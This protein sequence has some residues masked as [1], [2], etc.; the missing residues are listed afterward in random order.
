MITREHRHGHAY[1]KRK[2]EKKD[3]GENA[4]GFSEPMSGW[5]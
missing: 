3:L 4:G 2:K 5:W 1:A